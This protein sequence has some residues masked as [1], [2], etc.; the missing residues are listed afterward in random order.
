MLRLRHLPLSFA[1]AL[2]AGCAATAAQE[3][4]VPPAVL[5]PTPPPKNEDT[6]ARLHALFDAEWERGLRENPEGA[7]Y[8]GDR[9]Y[10]DRW[11]DQSPAAIEARHEEDADA[12][13]HLLEIDREK[14]SPDDQ[15]NYELFRQQLQDAI[16][17]YRFRAFLMPV[18]Q[19]GGVQTSD[20][21]AEVLPFAARKDY[22]DWLARLRS[23]DT[24]VDQTIALM[25]AGVAEQRTVPRVIMQ[26]VPAQI[27]QQLAKKPEDSLFYAPFKRMPKDIPA[28]VQQRLQAEARAAIAGT[29]IPAYRRFKGYVVKEYLPQCRS[30]V[31]ASSLPQGGEWYA[32]MARYH[33]TTSLTPDQI[34]Q[35]GLDEVA[36]IRG[37]METI[38]A[39]TG[40]KGSLKAYF[41]F[42]RSDPRFFYK[43]S[44][45][46][47]L[48]ADYRAI[49]KRIDGELPR[50]FGKLPRLPYGVRP[51]PMA[52]A[53]DQTTA[54]YLPG[55]ADGSRAGFYYVNLY[56]PQTRPRWEME[57]LT[58]HE[59]VPG[60]HLQLALQNE[61][62]EL[63]MFRRQGGYT[64]F[65]EGWGLYSESLGSEL[66]LYQDPYSR[67]GQLSYEMWRAVR[68][69]VDTG[70]HARGWTREQAIA[71]FKDNTPRPENDI[72]N[73]IDRYI[74]WP[75]QALAYKIGQ[76][77]IKE[78]RIRAQDRLGGRFELR[79]FHDQVLGAGALPLDVLEQRI[80]A[81][82]AQ[83]S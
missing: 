29:V 18:S 41:R 64:A 20:Q 46:E 24:P 21:L 2:C 23:I 80:D 48:L 56:Q 49:A 75:G 47:R 55:A 42:L 4:H 1:A 37:E 16:E 17:S 5:A 65:V 53:P 59:S 74:A 67:F 71:Y 73:E 78:L 36:R 35:I 61:L 27:D 83:Q 40:F 52:T 11:T 7:S 3:S 54:Y 66:G 62:G 76:L 6:G 14:L 19:Q 51:I 9:R 10:N 50:L 8:L 26:R 32:F 43:A 30:T 15:L 13:K 22:E 82:I 81:W 60:H 68:L 72:V 57:A 69:V 39:Q 63:P 70:M 25:R 33:T 79:A 31:G 38:K 28:E 58:A 77:K 34:H 12:L 44:E 45:G